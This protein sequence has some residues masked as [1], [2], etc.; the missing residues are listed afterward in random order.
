MFNLHKS[1]VVP[2]NEGESKFPF[3]HFKHKP[4]ISKYFNKQ[5]FYHTPSTRLPAL[6]EKCNN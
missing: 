6:L 1:A 5:D 3:Q 4:R 2:Y